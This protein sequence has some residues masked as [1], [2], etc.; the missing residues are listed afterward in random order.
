ME[1]EE[2][3]RSLGIADRFRFTGWVEHTRVPD[4]V[5]LA[6]IV[7]MPFS[8]ATTPEAENHGEVLAGV[9]DRLA[10]SRAGARLLVVVDEAPYAERMAGAPDR[11][12]ERREA[13]RAFVR[14]H[15]LDAQFVS[16]A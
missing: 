3:C 1:M 2:T 14:A 9:R 7:V 4:Y 10:A 11:I 6:D 13:W 16:L 5:R 12:A 15:G 8:L